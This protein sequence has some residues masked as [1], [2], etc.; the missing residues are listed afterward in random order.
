MEGG[1]VICLDG[2]ISKC[3]H[4]RIRRTPVEDHKYAGNRVECF[5]TSFHS[6]DRLNSVS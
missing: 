2:F 5:G 3:L 1:G 6:T 4:V